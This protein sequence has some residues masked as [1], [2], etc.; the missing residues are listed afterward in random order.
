MFALQKKVE[1]V[2]IIDLFDNLYKQP[3]AYYN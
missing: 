2:F 3:K 1:N